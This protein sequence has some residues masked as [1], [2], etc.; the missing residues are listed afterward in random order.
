M[1]AKKIASLACALL[2]A[3][4]ACPIKGYALEIGYETEIDGKPYYWDGSNFRPEG[5]PTI[6]IATLKSKEDIV[7]DGVTYS[8]K[9]E[10]FNCYVYEGVVDGVTCVASVIAPNGF[11]DG[12]VLGTN[13][14]KDIVIDGIS[15]SFYSCPG[16]IEELAS[17]AY[18]KGI[19][20]GITHIIDVDLASGEILS[21][22][23][24]PESFV[25]ES[26]GL[27]YSLA[28]IDSTGIGTYESVV[29]EI[30]YIRRLQN[31]F[32]EDFNSFASMTDITIN[33]VTYSV[34]LKDDGVRANGLDYVPGKSGFIYSDGS[35]DVIYYYANMNSANNDLENVDPASIISEVDGRPLFMDEKSAWEYVYAFWDE[36]RNALKETENGNIMTLEDEIEIPAVKGDATGDGEVD[37]LD[38]IVA[39]KAILGQKTLTSEQTQ[40]LDI[41]GNGIVDTTDSLAIMQYI[42]GLTENL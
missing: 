3:C 5:I 33:G 32:F 19:I 38:V 26:T 36:C 23:M 16:S 14:P 12:Q 2:L 9:E 31:W 10:A 39:N 4:S 11:Y 15:Y 7:I 28:E 29:G 13:I 30:T 25:D 37:I 18:Y 34:P 1:K 40:A 6:N 35:M 22:S 8:F 21:D 27:T 20:D 17:D 41:D 24:C 42:T